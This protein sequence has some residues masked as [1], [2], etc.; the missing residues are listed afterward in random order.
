MWRGESDDPK[1]TSEK[2][3]KQDPNEDEKPDEYVLISG[4]A[5]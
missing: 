3:N 2:R 4:R 1:V 5:N